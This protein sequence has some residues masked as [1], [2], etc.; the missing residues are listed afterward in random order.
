[1]RVTRRF[2][3]PVRDLLGIRAAWCI[4]AQQHQRVAVEADEVLLILQVTLRPRQSGQ[5]R[6]WGRPGF[7]EPV[8]FS[9]SALIGSVAPVIFRT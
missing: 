1:M 3:R 5:S 8:T 7:L 9:L 4:L 2:R 6:H